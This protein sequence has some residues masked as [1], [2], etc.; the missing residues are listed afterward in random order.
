MTLQKKGS[1]EFSF[2]QA[3]NVLLPHLMKFE[4]F[5]FPRNLSEEELQNTFVSQY[6]KRN[7]NLTRFANDPFLV[8]LLFSRRSSLRR[9][10]RDFE[11]LFSLNKDLI[12]D[13][14]KMN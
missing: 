4:H 11:N 6:V 7:D 3:R 8:N 2:N 13:V 5:T 9:Q 14:S 12:R 1:E 10:L